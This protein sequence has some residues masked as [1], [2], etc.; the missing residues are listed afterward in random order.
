MEIIVGGNEAF[1]AV[2]FGQQHQSNQSFL[3]GFFTGEVAERGQAAFGDFYSRAKARWENFHSEE[4]LNY[5]KAALNQLKGYF[6]PDVIRELHDMPSMQVCGSQMQRWIMAEPT[7][8]S[9][10]HQQRCDGYSETYVDLDPGQIG[11]NHYDWRRVNNGI[12]GENEEGGSKVAWFIEE[13]RQDDTELHFYDQ[14]T[15]LKAQSLAAHF[16]NAAGRDCT[17]VWNTDL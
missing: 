10:Y 7:V 2:A 12:V 5:G 9:L 14:C 3:A 13:L 8:R 11:E 1:R 4:A 17:S 15:I 16:M 6:Q